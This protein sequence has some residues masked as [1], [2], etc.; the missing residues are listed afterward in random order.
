VSDVSESEVG[1][2]K[3]EVDNMK[4][5]ND[6]LMYEIT[7][8]FKFLTTVFGFPADFYLPENY[9]TF[10]YTSFYFFIAF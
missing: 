2:Q 8:L 9:L 6:R 3:S 7:E 5:F 10:T 4:S 1:S